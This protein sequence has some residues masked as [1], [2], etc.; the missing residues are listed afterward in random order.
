MHYSQFMSNFLSH[1]Y[2]TVTDA[3]NLSSMVWYSVMSCFIMCY[4][5]CTDLDS[6]YI[7]CKYT[8]KL[9]GEIMQ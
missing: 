6:N 7:G 2:H 5:V 1:E 9:F 8:L 3:A 4:G